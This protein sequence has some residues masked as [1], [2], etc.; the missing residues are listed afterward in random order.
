MSEQ[1][2]VTCQWCGGSGNRE[3]C[4]CD[5]KGYITPYVN[6]SKSQTCPNCN[7]TGRTRCIQCDGSGMV[8]GK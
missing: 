6:K 5:G 1:K 3:C 2:M 8:E 4:Q 7:G